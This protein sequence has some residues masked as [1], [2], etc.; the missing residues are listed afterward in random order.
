MEKD[1]EKLA[2][3]MLEAL[4]E[5]GRADLDPT[6]QSLA[7]WLHVPGARV[8]EVMSR[9]GAQGLVD[10]DRCRL[11]MQGL[12]LAVSIDGAH[13]LSRCLAAA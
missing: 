11:T 1:D 12:V 10:A 9:L 5:M 7:D 4:Y 13:K 2:W 6:P 3:E 8:Q